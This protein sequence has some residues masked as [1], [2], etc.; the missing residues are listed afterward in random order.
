MMFHKDLTAQRW[1]RFSIFDQ[2]ANVYCEVERTIEWRKK[3]EREQSNHA[4]ER[5][6]ELLTLTIIDP[7]NKKGQRKELV[8]AREFMID[9]F[10]YD[11]QYSFTD[12]YWQNYFYQF[13]YAAAIAKGK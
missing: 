6:L 12:E 11:N 2:L 7:K 1:F 4:F 8:R 13:A 3:N 5:M 9:Y 10:M